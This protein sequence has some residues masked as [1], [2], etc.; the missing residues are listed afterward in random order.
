MLYSYA[1]ACTF[2]RLEIFFPMFNIRLHWRTPSNDTNM[3]NLI[4]QTKESRRILIFSID[5]SEKL[6]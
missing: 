3:F 1:Q 6:N 4:T 2:F 5:Q